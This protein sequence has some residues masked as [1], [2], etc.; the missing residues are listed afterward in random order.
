MKPLY[1]MWL[2]RFVGMHPSISGSTALSF[3]EGDPSN[4]KRIEFWMPSLVASLSPAVT[5]G[6]SSEGIQWRVVAFATVSSL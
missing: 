3:A 4:E 5:L 1:K 6:C 2:C